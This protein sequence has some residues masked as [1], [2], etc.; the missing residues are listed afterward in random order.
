MTDE[1]DP[2]ISDL[3]R[4]QRTPI[5]QLWAAFRNIGAQYFI[6]HGRQRAIQIQ[7]ND[8][9]GRPIVLEE[10]LIPESAVDDLLLALHDL[11]ERRVTD[12]K[13]LG[14]LDQY[15]A[16]RDVRSMQR[17]GVV[18]RQD[19]DEAKAEIRARYAEAA[20]RAIQPEETTTS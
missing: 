10:A 5:L 19:P 6:R 18:S 7:L 15:C 2:R 14:W 16:D 20:R 12:N 1:N 11:Y 3:W 8:A 9:N 4:G 13:E 17:G